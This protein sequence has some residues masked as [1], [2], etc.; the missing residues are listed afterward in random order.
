VTADH[1]H[2]NA[3]PKD[4]LG[5]DSVLLDRKR[6]DQLWA[7]FSRLPERDQQLLRALAATDRPSYT[8]I[9]AALDMPVGSIGPTRMRA[10]KRLHAILDESGYPFRD[11]AS[12]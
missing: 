5:L 10:L 11:T 8:A 12:R 3:A 2:F 4:S 1:R 9:A 6:D 7:C